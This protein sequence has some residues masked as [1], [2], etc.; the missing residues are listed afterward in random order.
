MKQKKAGAWN[1][2]ISLIC[3]YG[4]FSGI[5]GNTMG[6]FFSAIRSG[7][8]FRAGD[9]SLYYMIKSFTAA[10]VISRRTK[11]FLTKGRARSVMITD[12]ILACLSFAVMG[13]FHFLWQWYLSAIVMGFAL[14]NYFV[15]VPIV[16]NNWFVKRRGLVLGIAMSASGIIAAMLSPVISS[17]ITSIGWRSAIRIVGLI[18]LAAMLIS[19][20]L[21]FRFSPA[22]TGET[23]YGREDE[24]EK[25]AAS[26]SH[27]PVHYNIPDSIF[28]VLLFAALIPDMIITFASQVP[29]FATDIGYSLAAASLLNSFIMVGNISGKLISGAAI[30][31]FGVY[32]TAIAFISISGF[33]LLLYLAGQSS[34]PVLAAASVCFGFLYAISVNVQPMLLVDLYGP[35]DYQ[36]TMSRVKRVTYIVG[37]LASAGFPY[38]YDFTGSFNP[39]FIFG[40]AAAAVSVVLFLKLYRFRREQTVTTVQ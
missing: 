4:V 15:G 23:A 28:I 7:L 11:K 22:E 25:K 37:A 20:V 27:P 16:L 21:W 17:L 6:I 31:R 26:S 36:M 40:A 14:S 2:L 24:S 3:I 29:T 12:E 8:G 5:L 35:D 19:T 33:S 34:Y 1:V 13:S 18:S 9:L 39:V 30:D 10:A 32:P 38:V